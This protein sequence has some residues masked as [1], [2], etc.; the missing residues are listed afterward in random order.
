M[1]IGEG[2]IEEIKE[3]GLAKVRVSRD[4]LYVACSACAAAD[5]VKLLAYNT[6]GAAEGDH[7]RYEVDD[8]H[9]V[10]GAFVCFILPVVMLLVVA[11]LGYLLVGHSAGAIVGGIAGLLVS[12]LAVRKYDQSLS[13]IIDTKANIL[14]VIVDE[15]EE[16]EENRT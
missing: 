11:L 3:D 9:L 14:S 4:S 15:E 5:H 10:S 13:R 7:V 16:K 2:F 8:S 12:V 6:I 1:R